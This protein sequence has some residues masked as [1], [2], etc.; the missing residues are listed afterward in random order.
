MTGSALFYDHQI[1]MP[2]RLVIENV[3]S[4]REA[5]AE[6]LNYMQAERIEETAAGVVVA[7][8]DM[9]TGG[10]RTF[11]SRVL[12]NAAGPWIDR[13]RRS[14]NIDHHGIIHPTKGIH[15]V[16]PK[17]SD[18]AL[19]VSSRDG[20]MFFMIPLGAYSL[21][22]TTD[23]NYDGDLDDVHAD[24][25]D[26][27]YL[28]AESRRLLPGLKLSREAILYTYAGIRP[29]AFAGASESRISRKHRVIRE[30][31][32]GRL[33]TIAGGK[34]TTY[35]N[36]AKDV[37]DAACRVLGLRPRCS[38]DRTPL[39]GGLSAGYEDYLREAVP[40]WASQYSV[41]PELVRHLIGIY[42]SRSERILQ[43]IKEE[44]AL[45][46]AVSPESKD[47][48][49]QATYSVRE[50]GAK[51]LADIMLRRMTVGI[52]GSRGAGQAEQIA[53]I[54]GRDLKWNSDEKHKQ[55][56][57]YRRQLLKETACLKT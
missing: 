24:K 10:A 11:R 1:T 31:R 2:E 29:L 57:D 50:E 15:L 33:I 51:T 5:G 55:I 17:F 21:I 28:L 9:L 41:S 18:Q 34:L 13:V 14:G 16:L 44:P 54:A 6:L 45:G 19:F 47:V 22:G 25:S 32:Y 23:T 7:A 39:A 12:I 35:R 42:G 46:A 27:D 30:G 36:M 26:V 37:V 38:T 53:E 40:A 49:A 48:Y 20:R 4:A 43:L 56:E 52:T 3:I 8:R